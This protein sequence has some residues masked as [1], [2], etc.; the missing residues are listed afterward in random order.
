MW[1]TNKISSLVGEFTIHI[2][3]EQSRTNFWYQ[4]LRNQFQTRLEGVWHLKMKKFPK[5]EKY[6]TTFQP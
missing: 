4:L 3:T 2:A 5:L 6:F 1:L